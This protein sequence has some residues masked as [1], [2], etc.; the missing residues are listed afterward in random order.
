MIVTDP[1]HPF[2]KILVYTPD[3]EHSPSTPRNISPT[4][5]GLRTQ[6]FSENSPPFEEDV[7][8]KSSKKSEDCIL[9]PPKVSLFTV[10]CNASIPEISE[11]ADCPRVE[12]TKAAD[13]FTGEAEDLFTSEAED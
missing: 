9:H 13:L 4:L 1:P 7:P 11:K 8:P 5:S 10:N 12:S 2:G 3:L 6:D